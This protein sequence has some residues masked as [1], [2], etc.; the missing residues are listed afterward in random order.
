M[1]RPSRLL[2][3]ERP[4]GSLALISGELFGRLKDFFERVDRAHG[5]PHRSVDQPDVEEDDRVRH[6]L[7]GPLEFGEGA[8]RISVVE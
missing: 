4:G 3:V 2:V 6:Q 1:S 8:R 5:S 7:V